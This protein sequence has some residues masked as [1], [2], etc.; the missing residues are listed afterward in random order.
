MSKIK[1]V[2]VC[3]CPTGAAHTYIAADK[4][5]AAC[6]KAGVDCLVETQGFGGVEDELT[7]DDIE[8]ADYIVLANEVPL[9]GADR[10]DGYEEKTI[11]CRIAD[12]VHDS[13]GFLKAEI[14]K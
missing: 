14:L 8:S 9:E 3:A 13:E 10:F 11:S 2:A 12:L 7:E 4:F 1:V 6:E 5:S